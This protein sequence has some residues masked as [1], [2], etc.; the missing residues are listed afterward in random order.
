M[1]D[2]FKGQLRILK[3]KISPLMSGCNILDSIFIVEVRTPY[4]TQKKNTWCTLLH[5]FRT[6]R[7][8]VCLTM[9]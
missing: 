5:F 9:V 8:T 1:T 2:F 7:F 3:K 6:D 4:K